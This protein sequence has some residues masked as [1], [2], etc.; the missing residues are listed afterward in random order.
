MNSALHAAVAAAMAVGV[1]HRSQNGKWLMN[2]AVS[3]TPTGDAGV[4]A[5]VGYGFQTR[6]AGETLASIAIPLHRTPDLKG[7]LPSSATRLFHHA[8]PATG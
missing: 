8:K 7:G 6:N 3:T 1:T 2:G 4:R 5:Q